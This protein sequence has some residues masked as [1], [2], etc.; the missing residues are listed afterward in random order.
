MND[1]QNIICQRHDGVPCIAKCI[2]C[3]KPICRDCRLEF[4]YFCSEKCRDASE[5]TIDHRE[6][7]R[8]RN[9]EQ[10]VSKIIT[11][12]KVFF[13]SVVI[14]IVFLVAWFVWKIV[15]DPTGKIAWEW[16]LQQNAKPEDVC[17]LAKND[18]K[19]TFKSGQAIVFVHPDTGKEI[20]RE[21]NPELNNLNVFL[22]TTDSGYFFRGKN[23]IALV[24]T[25]G[26]IKWSRDFADK[27]ILAAAAG[28]IGI[29]V[30]IAKKY[31]EDFSENQKL[32]EKDFLGELFSIDPNNTV[33]FGKK[34][35][36]MTA[37]SGIT[38]GEKIF[39]YFQDSY[40]K[41][42]LE[43][44]LKGVDFQ[45]GREL[46]QI[47]LSNDTYSIV[48]AVNGQ[49]LFTNGGS[50]CA[51]SE[52]GKN[53]LW[54]VPVKGIYN[55]EQ[56]KLFDKTIVFPDSSDGMTCV[57]TSENKVLW[58]KKEL[59]PDE[60]QYLDGKMFMI[61][62]IEQAAA[63][64][65]NNVSEESKPPVNIDRLNEKELLKEF[66]SG[67]GRKGKIK[68]ER[69]IKCIDAKTG[70]ILWEQKIFGGEPVV[71]NGKLI[72]VRDTAKE[73]VVD[74]AGQTILL[75]L[76]PENGKRIFESANKMGFQE[77]YVIINRKLI[78]IQYERYGGFPGTEIREATISGLAA[79]I[80]N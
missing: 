24:G 32:G 42:K 19:I 12:A 7:E 14:L 54:T 64:S 52:D 35:N 2:G 66:T 69:K 80:L 33:R 72:V 79:F 62:S 39:T 34:I 31:S 48:K 5:Q 21:S 55:N 46:W 37:L 18:E 68:V 8:I 58:S 53:K 4:G 23:S 47:K 57:D 76:N 1:S 22:G 71:G 11:F 3:G 28:K 13:S 44:C 60:L 45:S 10:S 67:T 65:Q 29:L 38:L 70:E 56:I 74:L 61:S 26:K 27:D 6:K 17:I 36:F 78:G 51:V 9:D 43:R 30:C 50:L 59:K 40:E 41:G 25:E 73:A 20:G 49:I 63:S 15:F 75:Q 16:K 77:P